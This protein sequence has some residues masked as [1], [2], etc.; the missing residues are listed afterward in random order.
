MSGEL[1]AAH[2]ERAVDDEEHGGE[3]DV[4]ALPPSVGRVPAITVD[5]DD[6]HKHGQEKREAEDVEKAE[7]L[8][9]FGFA[10]GSW[11]PPLDEI[12]YHKIDLLS[13]MTG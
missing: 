7:H 5:V 1:V 4:E 11:K 6:G 9:S 13:M 2:H 12:K 10:R 3:H 8:P